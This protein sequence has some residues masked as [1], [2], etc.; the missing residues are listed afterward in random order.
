MLQ[1]VKSLTET[2]EIPAKMYPTLIWGLSYYLAIKY[3]PDKADIM[4]NK[5]NRSFREAMDEDTE[6]TLITIKGEN[7]EWGS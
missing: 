1:D 3:Q 7:M 4:E 2:L 5:Y 6:D